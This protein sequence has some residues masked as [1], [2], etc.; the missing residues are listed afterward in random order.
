MVS[1][2]IGGDFRLPLVAVVQQLLLVVEQ[3]LVRLG[4]VLEIRAF[5]DGVNRTGLLTKTAIDAFGHVDVVASRPSAAVRSL[6]GLDRDGLSRTDRLAELARDTALLS[7]RVTSQ[8]VLSTKPRTQRPFL[9]R[10]VDCGRLPEQRRER[11]AHRAKQFREKHSL[12]CMFACFLPGLLLPWPVLVHL[13]VAAT[14]GN[15]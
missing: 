9:E 8:G 12:N 15:R 13:N 7:R 11:D 1:L 5:H 3:L 2:K 6:F 4:G 10:V 14:V